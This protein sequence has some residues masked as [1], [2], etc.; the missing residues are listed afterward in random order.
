MTQ[1]NFGNI[2]MPLA[3]YE[4]SQMQDNSQDS[5]YESFDLLQ[6]HGSGDDG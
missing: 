5:S 2:E 4:H 3:M 6:R 1:K